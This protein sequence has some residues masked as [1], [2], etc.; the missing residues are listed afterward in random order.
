VTPTIEEMTDRMVSIGLLL[1]ILAILAGM[2]WLLRTDRRGQRRA[3][4]PARESAPQGRA[5]QLQTLRH[6]KHYWGVEIHSGICS[7]AKA[8]AGKQF[9]FSEAPSLPLE[10]CAAGNCTCAYLGLRERRTWHRRTQPDRRNAI[11]YLRNR[12][13]R[14]SHK[15]R[16]KADVWRRLR[17]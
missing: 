2:G 1:L 9:R 5:A 4:T 14:R 15:E 6:N 8:L 7:A 3:S 17:W 13:D 11:R 16:R 12:P 10:D